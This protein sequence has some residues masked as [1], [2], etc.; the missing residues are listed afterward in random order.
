M[1]SST[2][3]SSQTSTDQKSAEN[4]SFSSLK[5]NATLLARLGKAGLKEPT[6]IQKTAIPALLAG[7]DAEILAPT[8]TGKTACYLLPL[9]DHL[10]RKKKNTALIIVPTRELAR[11]VTEMGTLLAARPEL[12]PFAVYGGTQDD[13]D[14]DYDVPPE[15]ARLIVA[16]PGRL[17]DMLRTERVESASCRFLVLDEGDR[18]M[19]AEFR[20]EM[21]GILALLP[22]DRQ[23]VLVSATGSAETMAAARQF[24]HRPV[25]IEPEKGEKPSIRQA[26]LF[27]DKASK[28]TATEALLRRHPDRSAIVFAST[29]DEVDLLTKQLRKRGLKVVGLHGGLTQPARNAAID[30]FSSGKATVLVATDIAARGLDV[31]QVGQVINMSPPEQPDTYLHRIGRT[32]RAG[33]MGWAATLCSAEERKTMRK[34]ES[35]LGLKLVALPVPTLAQDTPARDNPERD[36]PARSRK[37]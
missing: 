5:L 13:P 7:H 15:T 27:V 36:T 18:L 25:R 17:L 26:V 29:R 11:Q 2:A 10:L 14:R 24:L 6:P 34:V 3:A 9:F 12:E 23:S 22:R 31:E 30:A 4:G 16:T 1:P 8:G 21:Q 35:T 37:H 28:P 33:R 20:D 32:G 19:T